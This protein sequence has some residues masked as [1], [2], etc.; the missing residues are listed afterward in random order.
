M[1]LYIE[2]IFVFRELPVDHFNNLEILPIEIRFL[3]LYHSFIIVPQPPKFC[4][5]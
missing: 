1:L 5:L 2:D 4:S 3:L